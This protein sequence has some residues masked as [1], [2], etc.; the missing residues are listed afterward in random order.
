MQ[1]ARGLTRRRTWSEL[2]CT[3]SLVYGKCQGSGKQPYQVTVDLT[4]PAYR[5]TCPSRKFPCKHGLALL[6]LWVEHGDAVG[7]V[8]T[9]ADFAS[10][11][12]TERATRR[13]A[14]SDAGS[15]VVVDPEAQAR[16]QAEREATMTAGLDELER[17]LGDMVRQGLAAARRQPYGFWDAMA[18]RLVDAQMPALADRVRE[19]GGSLVS[20]EDWGDALLV[21][22]GRWHLAIE[23]WRGRDQLGPTLTGDLRAFLGWPRRADEAAGFERLRDRWVVAGVRQ[24]A[25]GRIVSQ[26]TWMWGQGSGRWVLLL[27]FATT[28]AALRTAQVVGSVVEDELVLH[29]GS[30]PPRA[31]LSEGQRVVGNGTLPESLT[32]ADTVER[33]SGWSAANP[34]CDRL[35]IAVHGAVVVPDDRRWWLQDADGDRLPLAPAADRL[36]MLALSGGHPV[37]VVGEWE[38]GVV[39]PMAVAPAAAG[40]LVPL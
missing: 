35:P 3:D 5:C 29:P 25:D 12:R 27:D 37:T 39:F 32:I 33:L 2:G 11:W 20:R 16:R 15:T 18:A 30:D 26:R 38:E 21:E 8:A 34:W 22:A 17:W 24:G 10:E 6:L 40:D 14:K 19:V 7:D 4:E 1:A 36:L 23:A 28:A 13:T 9:A 31:A